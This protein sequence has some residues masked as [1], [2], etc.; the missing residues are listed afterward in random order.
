MNSIS[1]DEE[2]KTELC[3]LVDRYQELQSQYESDF[4]RLTLIIDGEKLVKKHL[5][6]HNQERCPFCNGKLSLP[7]QET[8]AE[9]AKI[10]IQKIILQLDELQSFNKEIRG[11]ISELTSK[12]EKLKLKKSKI[13][14]LVEGELKPKIFDLKQTIKNYQ[15][16]IELKQKMELIDMV[17]KKFSEDL[18]DIK[19]ESTTGRPL[20]R[21][22]DKFNSDFWTGMTENIKN[23]LIE[24][25]YSFLDDVVFDKRLFD[26]RINGEAKD[27][28]HGKGYCSFLNT[29]VILAYR[30]M[31]N[32]IALYDPSVFVIDTPL[33]GLDEGEDEEKVSN[34]QRSLFKYLM[35]HQGEG[36]L[37][38]IEN[39][40]ELPDLDYKKNNVNEIVFTRNESKGRF[41][42][43][44]NI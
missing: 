5:E 7:K 2:K 24:C 14:Q 26:L 31:L 16:Y 22:I 36:Q 41:G 11:E 10:E 25:H 8:Y 40:N 6:E 37:I 43:L 13:N 9:T 28:S 15:K 27:V 19:S 20:Y 21:P 17:K 34:M 32:E 35:N 23:I 30:K 38:I 4:E 1:K 3:L 42:F 29:V 39:T 44:Y 33:L 18:E 12:I